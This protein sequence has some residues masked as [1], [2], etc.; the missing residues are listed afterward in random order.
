MAAGLSAGSASS[1]RMYAHLSWL[2]GAGGRPEPNVD[3]SPD[4]S[5]RLNQSPESK[6]LRSSDLERSRSLPACQ[7]DGL[8]AS[9][10]VASAIMFIR[11]RSGIDVAG[12]SLNWSASNSVSLSCAST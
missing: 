7:N 5:I 12:G 3:S 9:A 10:V 4:Q 11:T 1:G 8:C 6:L 2:S